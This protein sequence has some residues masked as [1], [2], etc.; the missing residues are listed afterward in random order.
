M[1]SATWQRIKRIFVELEPLS[2]AERAKFLVDPAIGDAETRATLSALFENLDHEPDFLDNCAIDL[3]KTRASLFTTNT[4]FYPIYPLLAVAGQEDDLHLNLE[5]FEILRKVGAGG[6]GTVYEAYDRDM[7]AKVALKHLDRATSAMVYLFKREFRAL[8]H[9]NHRNLVALYDFFNHNG[10]W[11]YTMEFVQGTDFVSSAALKENEDRHQRTGRIRDSLKE[12]VEGISALHARGKLHRDIKPSNVMVANDSRVVLLD[13]GLVLDVASHVNAMTSFAG[14]AHYMSPEQ[15]RGDLLTPATDWYSA[16][17]MLYETLTGIRPPSAAIRLCNGSGAVLDAPSAT[18]GVSKQLSS[19]CMDM[20]CLEPKCR[21]SG[22]E[23]ANRLEISY[24]LKARELRGAD[25]R[26][27]TLV[28]REKELDFLRSAFDRLVE[29]A[30]KVVCVEGDP[31]IGKSTLV[32]IFLSGLAELSDTVIF[33]G[34]C[35]ERE[36]VPFNALDNLIDELSDHLATLSPHELDLLVPDDMELLCEMFPVLGWLAPTRNVTFPSEDRLQLHRRAVACIREILTRI[37]RRSRLV[38]FIDDLQWGDVDSTSTLL[39]LLRDNSSPSMLFVVAFRTEDRKRSQCLSL[40]FDAAEEGPLAHA[41][42]LCLSPLSSES[43]QLFAE[44]LLVNVDSS[45]VDVG[46]S[47]LIVRESGGNPYFMKELVAYVAYCGSD[48]IQPL[49]TSGLTLRSILCAR[50]EMLPEPSRRLLEII[51]VAGQPVRNVDAIRA[52]GLEQN[53][54]AAITFLRNSEFVR[55]A[56]PSQHD[57]IEPFHGRLRET[58]LDTI[59]PERRSS[60]H[61]SLAATLEQSGSAAPEVLATHFEGAGM[62]L[63]AALSYRQAGE[64][65]YSILAFHR[66]ADFFGRAIVLGNFEGNELRGVFRR[67]GE[68]FANAG[69]AYEAARA[70]ESAAEESSQDGLLSLSHSGY[71]YAASG[72]IEQGKRAFSIVLS[73]MGI[74][75]PLRGPFALLSLLFIRLRLALGRFRFQVQKASELNTEELARVD[76]C[77]FIGTALGLVELMRG[78][79]FTSYSLHLALK[80]GDRA[81]IARGLT[82]E[83]AIAASQSIGGKSRSLA[84]FSICRP[85]VAELGD[86][87][88]SG[89]L[90]L[91]EGQAHF[92]NGEWRLSLAKFS[93]AESLFSHCNGTSFEM[94]TLNGFRLQTL[95]YLGDFLTLRSRSLELLESARSAGDLYLESFIAG[96]IQPFLSLTEDDPDGARSWVALAME[97]WSAPGYH[98]QHA[99][100]DQVRLWIEL[101]CGRGDVA[102]VLIARRWKLLKRSGLM[103]NQN[104]RAKMLDVRT[105]CHLSAV[106]GGSGN[107]GA[108]Q[109]AGVCL[110]RLALEKEPYLLGSELSLEAIVTH[111]KGNEVAAP[112]LLENAIKALEKWEMRDYWSS[113][114]YALST[115]LGQ[116]AGSDLRTAADNWFSTQQIQN[117]ER[118]VRMRIPFAIR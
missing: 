76:V 97:R 113:A 17:V 43:S 39:E 48:S 112:V 118:W 87:K 79:A 67:K 51:A 72:H 92:S 13:F 41:S 98:L 12:L 85:M 36:S 96:A 34:R 81:R 45:K 3:I 32:E 27:R 90:A 102:E 6:M 18:E 116:D 63:R 71:Y 108:L 74:R 24:G 33:K 30:A 91:T 9:V 104:L 2:P 7:G 107:S 68:A 65:A 16:G 105:R 20:L 59:T 111:L 11:F 64:Q 100:I 35:Y 94:A 89:I 10:S 103:F 93:E 99:L 75:L 31:G 60:C 58:V 22:A 115:W 66:A 25:S 14:T 26:N 15:V 54:V 1:N 50:T 117:P 73:R 23:I 55:A 29:G 61:A 57:S 47:E 46:L 5:R 53:G 21:P 19:L 62:M 69:Q 52:A 83:A 95:V 114:A 28:G 101:Y 8:A 110:R 70:F 4:P 88:T 37:G 49:T 106:K 82:W 86:P 44:S 80:S 109:R 40:L 84:L 42:V 77:W 56:S 78:A 38:I